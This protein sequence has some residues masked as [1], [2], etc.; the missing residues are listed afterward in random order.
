MG[1]AILQ[2]PSIKYSHSPTG[3]TQKANPDIPYYLQVFH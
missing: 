2:I 1:P 3:I